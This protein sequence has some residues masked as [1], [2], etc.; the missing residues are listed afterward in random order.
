MRVCILAIPPLF[1]SLWACRRKYSDKTSKL[2]GKK[3]RTKRL[4]ELI[5]CLMDSIDDINN[6]HPGPGIRVCVHRYN[7]IRYRAVGG[8]VASWVSF[9][10]F[11]PWI[12]N[13]G[14][15][16]PFVGTSRLAI[17]TG[18]APPS[19]N[20]LLHYSSVDWWGMHLKQ[21]G[22]A[23]SSWAQWSKSC[24]ESRLRTRRM[25]KRKDT[26]LAYFIGQVPLQKSGQKLRIN[27]LCKY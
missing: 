5:W 4:R 21:Q 10:F 20:F 1:L 7:I 11:T 2:K 8:V 3:K 14:G 23:S 26:A 18:N 27:L 16:C 15:F 17:Y 19:P 25:L 12:P 22:A 9:F 24:M 6:L 13:R